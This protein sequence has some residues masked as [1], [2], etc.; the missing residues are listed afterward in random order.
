M[1]RDIFLNNKTNL[2]KITKE[3]E[4]SLSLIK[5]YIK[6]NDSKK[7]K[8]IFSKTKKIRKL[9]EKEKQE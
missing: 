9:I 4:K 8:K 5:N 2:L 6:K 1:W 7:L 3:F